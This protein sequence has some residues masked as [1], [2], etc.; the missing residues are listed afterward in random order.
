MNLSQRRKI[1]RNKWH[2]NFIYFK[3]NLVFASIAFCWIAFVLLLSH[4]HLLTWTFIHLLCHATRV[5]H[6]THFTPSVKNESTVYSLC[7]TNQKHNSTIQVILRQLEKTT[8]GPN[9]FLIAVICR[10]A[11]VCTVF[12]NTWKVQHL[13][14][15]VSPAYRENCSATWVSTFWK[16]SSLS[17]ERATICICVSSVTDYLMHKPPLCLCLL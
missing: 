2:I 11:V 13:I 9:I 12:H 15:I 5:M 8:N 14:S 1:K 16:S 6:R 7:K 3:I 17:V 4:V 10:T